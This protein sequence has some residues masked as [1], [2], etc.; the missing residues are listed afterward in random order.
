MA[1]LDNQFPS[2]IALFWRN[3]INDMTRSA[4]FP[5]ELNANPKVSTV[6]LTKLAAQ[7]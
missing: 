1:L 2:R 3:T 6:H 7:T 4:S 5:L